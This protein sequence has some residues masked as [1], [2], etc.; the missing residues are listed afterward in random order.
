[1]F[2]IIIASADDKNFLVWL[3]PIPFFPLLHIG[4]LHVRS[5][6]HFFVALQ[7][8]VKGFAIGWRFWRFGKIRTRK[9]YLFVFIDLLVSFLL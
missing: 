1:L 6:Q 4:D 5:G 9:P 2:H 7:E 3:D 8:L